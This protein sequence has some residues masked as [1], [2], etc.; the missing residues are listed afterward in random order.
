MK[1][2]TL[3]TEKK[4]T[5]NKAKAAQHTCQQKIRQTATSLWAQKEPRRNVSTS[6]Q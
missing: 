2:R 5:G 3:Q 1:V 6:Q 4:N